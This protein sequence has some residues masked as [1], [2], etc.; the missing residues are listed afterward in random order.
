MRRS[1][2]SLIEVLVALALMSVVSAVS[3]R[4]LLQQR[5]ALA[6]QLA[7]SEGGAAV[8][9]A[10]AFFGAEL[11]TLDPRDGD[12]MVMDRSRIVYRASRAIG[13]LCAHPEP[14]SDLVI[15]APVISWRPI[16]TDVDSVLIFAEG[17][18]LT[19]DDD[20]WLHADVTGAASEACDNGADGRRVVLG[21]VTGGTLGAV[22]F[23]AP[24]RFG[25]VHEVRLYRGG[26]GAWWLGERR[27]SKLTG[28][29]TIQPLLGPLVPGGLEFRYRDA[30]G[31]PAAVA[32]E[33]GLIEIAIQ[34]APTTPGTTPL[35]ASLIRVALRGR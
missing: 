21:S 10:A 20:R 29:P 13:F 24:V 31:Q 12:L 35:P 5:M 32:S 34:P 4:L 30:N 16:D 33:V 19:R 26:D 9:V 6:A 1:G 11:A 25:S 3:V 18:L 17:D 22:R 7:R 15:E 14:D 8:R 27:Y 2:F 28:W 23:G